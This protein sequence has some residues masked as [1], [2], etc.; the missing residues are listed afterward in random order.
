MAS[1]P[2]PGIQKH[3]TW[4]GNPREVS[5]ASPETSLTWCL[6]QLSKPER[7]A[8]E[9]HKLGTAGPDTSG[10]RQL[11]KRVK[12]GQWRALVAIRTQHIKGGS[13]GI[14]RFRGQGGL[15]TLLDLLKHPEC[16]RKTLDLALSILANCCTERQT[17]VEVR[18]LDGISIVVGILKKNV[19]METIQNRAARALGNLAMD[20]ESSTLIHSAGGV[21]LLLLC[22]SLASAPS[23]LS[24]DPLEAP[25]SKLECAQS[26][27]RALLYLADTPSNRLLLLTQG[28]LTALA[29]LIAPEYPLGLRRAALR[30][31]HEL[32]RSCGVECAREVSRSGVLAQLGVMASGEAAKPFEELALKTLANMCTQGCLR[33]LV[34]SLGVIQ[35][36]TEEVKKD[37]LKSGVFLKALCLCC[38]EAV[39]RAKVKESG[40]LEVLIGFLGVNRSHPLDRLVILACVDFVYDEAA[41]EQLQELGIVPLL[42][43]RLVELAKG[44]EPSAGKMDVSLT[45][46]M[47][48]SELLST[49]CF[50]SF[51]F[52][53]PEG[54]RK[55]EMGK[56]HVLGSS[57]FLSLRSWLVSEGL[58][59]SEGDLLDSPGGTE[60][61][62]G[63][64]HIPSSSPQTSS[65]DCHSPLKCLSPTRSLPSSTPLSAP[66]SLSQSTPSTSMSSPAQVHMSSPSKTADL[67]P[68]VPL[69]SST[70]TPQ[71]QPGS[72]TSTPQAQPGSSTSDLPSSTIP[73]LT[74][75]SPSKFSSPPR[76]RPR[77][78]ST[79][80]SSVVPLD[81]P[82]TVSRPQAYHHPYHPE[83]WAP[84]SP[85]LLLLS[86][87]SHATDPS[88]ALVNSGIIS[89]LLFYLSQ[90]QDPSGRCFRM[91]CR[92][93]CN[94]NCL[95]ALVRTGSVALIRHHLVQR[96]SDPESWG[97][98]ERQTDRV[99]AK[100][101][102]LGL[103]LLSNLRVQCESGFGSGVL[104]HVILSGSESD[105]L[106]CALSL[107]LVNGNKVL[108]KKLLLDNG[109]LLLALEPL[110]CNED[111]EEE[112]HHTSECRRLLSDCLNSP[113]H[114]SAPQL[115]S[116]Y[117]SLLIG[118]LSSLMGCPKTVLAK[119]RC[120]V[121][122]PIKP[123]SVSQTGK[124]SPPPLKKPRLVNICPYNDSTFDLLF[125]LDDGSQVSANREAVAGA[126]G[127]E[128]VGSEYF[129]ALLRGSFGEAQG[130]TGEAIPIRDVSQGMLLPVLHYLHGCRLNKDGETAEEQGDETEREGRGECQI[131][132][133]LASEGL[134]VWRDGAEEPSPEAQSFQKTPLAETMMG[135][136]RFLVT[137]LQREVEDLCVS[138]LS[139]SAKNAGRIADVGKKPPSNMDQ[140]GSEGE[141]ADESLANRTSG[142]EL[143]GS[144]AQTDSLAPTVTAGQAESLHGS[145][146]QPCQQTEGRRH[147]APGPGQKGISAPKTTSGLETCVN[148]LKSSSASKCCKR[149]SKLR[150][151]SN[152]QKVADSVQD[153]KV[154]PGRWTLLPQVYWFSQRYSYPGLGRACLS[155]LLGSQGF[156]QP[157]PSSLAADCLCRL[158]R[159][160]DCTETL[161]RDLVSL[162]T[163]ALS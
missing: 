63:S 30:T 114:V 11:A 47:F 87:F 98:G 147:S 15:R 1:K 29:P 143:S 149:R 76:K 86:R 118:C 95:Q 131:L 39:N 31:L 56:E 107:P 79:T 81:T 2:V 128:V 33:P 80:R 60:G 109:G 126:E 121:L 116:L 90:H 130:R 96:G 160:A 157:R 154:G 105:K 20:P 19:A 59:S 21:P 152:T 9:D 85:I 36:F 123:L 54:N 163:M 38:K 108:L 8:A 88:A 70:S 132:G 93:S 94:P 41:L 161:K 119:R 12:A 103:A 23:P 106:N 113:Q 62:W 32:T 58:I 50:D 18:K 100:V 133:S 112:D 22:V 139:C 55:E 26:A 25:S 141:S 5:S 35:K 92:L 125:L 65:T 111:E 13:S 117:F 49:S 52:P 122:S 102:Q 71:A 69:P 3:G 97:A 24:D 151:V 146:L 17:R 162:A 158:A 145:E 57:S 129:R 153:S 101:K 124:A 104:S 27:A 7:A 72:S 53:P 138:L 43:A 120:R 137:E 142:L 6:S 45:S 10:H 44:E 140:Y 40:G 37:G 75:V 51:D 74:S 46:T 127:T 66:K 115:H 68:C 150:S 91:L 14:T 82:P 99:K 67:P 4:A 64:L 77:V 78:P 159:E 84:E 110:G 73:P 83:P 156:S 48:A 136:C 155:L 144:E 16:S 42:V 134:G 89:G 28:T 135:A 61:D 148:P 34:G